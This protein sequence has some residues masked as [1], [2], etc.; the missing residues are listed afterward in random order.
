[1]DDRDLLSSSE[2]ESDGDYEDIDFD[3]DGNGVN[4]GVGMVMNDR[5]IGRMADDLGDESSDT[6]DEGDE[7]GLG[8]PY[9]TAG[10]F[11]D[12]EEGYASAASSVTDDGDEAFEF[13]GPAAGLVA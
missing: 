1:M 2:T 10:Q 12:D 3:M 4:G 8:R 9:T 11:R 13:A 6:E 7:D 5:A